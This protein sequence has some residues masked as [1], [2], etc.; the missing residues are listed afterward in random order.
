[1]TSVSSVSVMWCWGGKYIDAIDFRLLAGVCISIATTCKVV[2]IGILLW[3]MFV[4]TEMH[5]P[6]FALFSPISI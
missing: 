4:L 1:M 2:M 3:V 5:V 6:P